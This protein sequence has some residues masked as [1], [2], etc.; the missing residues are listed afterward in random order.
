MICL[1]SVHRRGA[2][3]STGYFYGTLWENIALGNP[4]IRMESVTDFAARTGLN[5][6][7]NTLKNGYDTIL[8]PTG[9][10]L[11]RSVIHKI[12][13]IRALVGKPGLLLLEE[14]WLN[15]ENEHRSQIIQLLTEIKTRRW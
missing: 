1:L 7:I 15:S 13:L 10:R 6:F 5:E 9:K 4:A 8:D 14:P 2:F 12:L 11:P 3:E